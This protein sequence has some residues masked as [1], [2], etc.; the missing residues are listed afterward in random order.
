M[1]YRRET[2]LDIQILPRPLGWRREY[3]RE[4][5]RC[6]YI[7]IGIATLYTGASLLDNMY[8]IP[9]AMERV[10]RNAQQTALLDS[11]LSGRVD[12]LGLGKHPIIGNV[13]YNQR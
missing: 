12:T 7:A 13:D 11:F 9:R 4:M 3:K 8:L 6:L 10:G 5:M 2:I 1:R